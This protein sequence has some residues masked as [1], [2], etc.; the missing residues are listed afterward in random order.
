MLSKHYMCFYQKAGMGH[1][2]PRQGAVFYKV[3]KAATNKEYVENTFGVMYEIRLLD[4]NE[5]E[6][7]PDIEIIRDAWH[8]CRNNAKY[9]RINAFWGQVKRSSA[10]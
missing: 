1:I 3:H 7:F 10:P 6:S 4:Y 9:T 5:S 2:G 8:G